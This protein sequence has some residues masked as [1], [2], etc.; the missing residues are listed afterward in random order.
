MARPPRIDLPGI[1]QH[2]VQRGDRGQ[3]CFFADCD[4]VRYLRDL[5]DIAH[6]EY[7][8]VHAYV[9]MADHVHLLVTPMLAGRVGRMMRTLG[10]GY[11]RYVNARHR[12]TGRLWEGRYKACAILDDA[13][14]LRCQRH[15]ELDPVR[16]GMVGDPVRYPWSSHRGNATPAAE[17][18][19]TPHR[20][21]LALGAD[22]AARRRA[23][24]AL[25]LAVIAP[26][27]ADAIRLHLQRQQFYAPDRLRHAIDVQPERTPGPATTGGPHEHAEPCTGA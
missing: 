8:A 16:A 20:A 21:W 10:R 4:R 27:E 17:A 26:G 9:L 7:C 3:P 25:A 18:L 1:P 22:D 13:Y 23:W 14:F 15:I 2:V 5:R 6:R 24:R 11:A 19:L 12:R